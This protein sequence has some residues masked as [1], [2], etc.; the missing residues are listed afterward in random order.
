MIK[1]LK[2]NRL[3]VFAAG[4]ALLLGTV[5]AQTAVAAD[6]TYS[7]DTTVSL[8]SP[9]INITI[10]S[11]SEAT[12]VTVNAGTIDATIPGGSYFEV[13]SASRDLT[14]TGY[15]ASN[16]AFTNTCSTANSTTIRMDVSS[17]S[18]TI[19]I[20][21][22]AGQ[23]GVVTSTN[24]GGGG[25]GGG[26]GQTTTPTTPT[27]PASTALTDAHSNGT[28]VLDG[29][30]IYLIRDGKRFG[31]RDP[32]EYK[33]HGYEFEQAVAATAGDKALPFS[34]SD[35][36]KS[37]EGTLVLDT[38]D[39]RTVYMIGTNNTKRGFTSEAVF[40]ALGYSFADL[41][42]INLADYPAGPVID[43]SAEAHPEGALVLGSDGR[44]VWWIRNGSRQGFESETVFYTYG[45]T[46]ARVVVGNSADMA[47]QEGA[48]V[49]LRD[50]TIVKD[51]EIYYLISDGKKLAFASTSA[52]T[53]RGHNL[54]S[55]VSANLS[56]YE[57]GASLE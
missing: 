4:V 38:V 25:G 10:E 18:E 5:F 21:P 11:G 44:T 27:T 45:F 57:S 54:S 40:K 56:Q 52:L 23:C 37:L 17:G 28:L 16:V 12:S 9:A 34:E 7:A 15:T 42:R 20:T 8:S 35:I 36:I 48:L 46:W 51:G 26:G 55:A 24:N 29:Q 30:T 19:T 2:R 49:K 41:I 14:I 32:D 47:L 22:T 53:S 13:T 3:A 39:G 50:G 43:S 31:F 1:N 33:S 6:L